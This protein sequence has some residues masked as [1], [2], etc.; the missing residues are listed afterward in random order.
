M[1]SLLHTLLE[2]GHSTSK[3][4]GFAH[5]PDVKIS[6]GE[7]T[8]TETNL[9]EIRRRHPKTVELLT[10]SKSQESK[11]TGADWEW[12]IIGNAYTLKMRIQA[13]RI[14]K[15]GGIGN[16]N[17][18]GKEATK[19]QIDLLIEDAKANRLFPAYCFYCA[20]P[21]RT[22]WTTESL[23][24]EYESLEAG[25]LIADAE[26]V[27]LISPKKLDEI[28][29][30]TI[31]WHFLCSK[32]RF[33]VNQ[34]PHIQKFREDGEVERYTETFLE[35]II[36][37]HKYRA[38]EL[39]LPTIFQLNSPQSDLEDRKGI[40]RTD[41]KIYKKTK[42]KHFKRRGITRLLKIDVRKLDMF[43]IKD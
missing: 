29:R 28:E 14:Y 10:F 34:K 30:N 41:E 39:D 2:L 32:N 38:I 40:S 12:H 11:N 27:K 6:Y 7:E 15:A 36:Q 31:P 9:L 3:N 8:I 35:K 20:E 22:Y 23:E 4:L 13:K 42:A 19:P 21:Q 37:P 16:L 18:M 1:I 25:C 43:S 5:L 17:Q 33:A 26:I 24:E